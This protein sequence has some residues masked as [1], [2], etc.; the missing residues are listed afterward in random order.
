MTHMYRQMTTLQKKELPK[1]QKPL[2]G[3]LQPVL[4]SVLLVYSLA[5][6]P[7]YSNAGQGVDSNTI[8]S[9][10][11]TTTSTGTAT[12]ET[13]TND[14]GSETTTLT[15][16]ITTTTTTTTVTQTEVGNVVKNPTFTNSQGGGSSTDWTI[17]AGGGSVC[18]FGPTHGFMTSYGTS[19]LY[20]SPSQRDRG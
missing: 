20:T 12:S 2:R 19:L 17:A 3:F 6:L 15:T 10:T 7:S 14:D 1:N 8:T 9:G 16:P 11:T 13:V 18:A 4:L 5:C